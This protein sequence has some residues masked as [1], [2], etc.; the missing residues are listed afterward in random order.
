LDLFSISTGR[1]TIEFPKSLPKF[2]DVGLTTNGSLRIAAK[3]RSGVPYWAT[4]PKPKIAKEN[5]MLPKN[6]KSPLHPVRIITRNPP[7]EVITKTTAMRRFRTN[8]VHGETTISPK[9]PQEDAPKAPL[10]ALSSTIAINANVAVSR[11]PGSLGFKISQKPSANSNGRMAIFDQMAGMGI[12]GERSIAAEEDD[13]NRA[14][15][16]KIAPATIAENVLNFDLIL[17]IPLHNR[18]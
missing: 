8:I 3:N 18:T 1:S 15:V 5:A 13:F 16:S 17:V 7:S 2:K 12:N 9:Q 10:K 6:R 14:A 11:T 4:T